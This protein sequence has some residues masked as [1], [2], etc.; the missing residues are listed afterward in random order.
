M[1][2]TA[3]LRGSKVERH[4]TDV[5]HDGRHVNCIVVVFP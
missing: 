5:G 4:F 3:M 2:A 1:T